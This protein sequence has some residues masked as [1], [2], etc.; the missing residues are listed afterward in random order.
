[1]SLFTFSTALQQFWKMLQ[2]GCNA[3][4][5]W[6]CTLSLR[7]AAKRH[8]VCGLLQTQRVLSVQ[9]SAQFSDWSLETKSAMKIN[10]SARRKSS[11]HQSWRRTGETRQILRTGSFRIT[12]QFLFR[13]EKVS[14]TFVWTVDK[15]ANQH[16]KVHFMSIMLTNGSL[17]IEL[18]S[19]VVS[20]ASMH[21]NDVEEA[22]C[23]S[24]CIFED[25]CFT[26]SANANPQI[27][28]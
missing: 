13:K 20:A 24:N 10:P 1:M 2:N 25:N 11:S 26:E 17:V 8:I 5:L 16:F 23:L 3:S 12:A 14:A 21:L 22:G 15:F 19:L 6:Q 7:N 4:N 28:N 18:T 9:M 27:G